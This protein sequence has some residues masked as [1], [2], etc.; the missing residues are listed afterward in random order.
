VNAD[1]AIGIAEEDLSRLFEPF[2]SA[3]AP[4]QRYSI[5]PYQSRS[6]PIACPIFMQM[7][8]M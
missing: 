1:P 2:C 8:A 4:P 6:A 5:V 3:A 7:S